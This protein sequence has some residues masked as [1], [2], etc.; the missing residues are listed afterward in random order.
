MKHSDKIIRKALEIGEDKARAERA[1]RML[2]EPRDEEC[3]PDPEVV[4]QVAPRAFTNWF[5]TWIG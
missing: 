4:V 2:D 1:E 3:E 5:D